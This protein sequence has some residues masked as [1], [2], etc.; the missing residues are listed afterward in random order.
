M[1]NRR[2]NHVRNIT[3]T[4]GAAAV[5]A[6]A[7]LVLSACTASEADAGTE[8]SDASPTVTETVSVEPA[9][10]ATSAP[11]DDAGTA[12]PA[13]SEAPAADGADTTSAFIRAD[14]GSAT[15]AVGGTA[16]LA[17]D[18]LPAPVGQPVFGG[19]GTLLDVVGVDHGQVLV[20]RGEPSTES[21]EVAALDPLNDVALTGREVVAGDTAWWEVTLSDGVGWVPSM[22]LGALTTEPRDV[23]DQVGD[24]ESSTAPE[25]LAA[26]GS[27]WA[28]ANS[29]DPEAYAIPSEFDPKSSDLTFVIDVWDYADDSVRGERLVVEL[30][31]TDAGNPVER[32][33]SYSIC[34]RGVPEGDLCP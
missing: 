9:E 27:S 12:D 13:A 23:T 1:T 26:I 30:I 28:T 29:R 2:P 34:A 6:A 5:A 14:D 10:T 3:T 16:A 20:V 7:A 17:D 22:H 4:T 21:A 32:V 19:E 31:P 11:A 33:D 8:A 24:I 18:A 25:T 15:G